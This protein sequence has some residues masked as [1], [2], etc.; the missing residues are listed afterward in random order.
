MTVVCTVLDH[1]TLHKNDEINEASVLGEMI[2]NNNCVKY[3][4]KTLF[5]FRWVHKGIERIKH[6]VHNTEKRL[7]TLDEIQSKIGFN[8]ANILFE[9]NALLNA[10]PSRWK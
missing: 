3:K 4:E 2:F 7:L 6:I 8:K 10:L 9:Y 5:L 1:K